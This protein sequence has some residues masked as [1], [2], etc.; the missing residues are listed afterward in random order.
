[1]KKLILTCLCVILLHA[2]PLYSAPVYVD[3]EGE[4]FHGML[5]SPGSPIP[6]QSQLSNQLSS[7]DILFTSGNP[8]IAVVNLGTGH[9]TSGING[10]GGSTPESG[11]LTYY[12]SFPIRVSFFDNGNISAPMTTDFVSIRGDNQTTSGF[13]VW[14]YAFDLNGN[15]IG[16]D[17]KDDIGNVGV[18]LML[19]VLAPGIHSVQFFGTD[20]GT[21]TVAFDDLRFNTPVPEPAT[22]SLL[23]LGSLVLL[24]KRKA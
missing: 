21:G 22:L 19:T 3:F 20:G 16:S 18:A 17:T 5:N 11:L 4:E 23:G 15:V 10:I 24:R 7:L 2:L 13:P 1:M 6:G 8:Y 9:A 12:Q 14:L